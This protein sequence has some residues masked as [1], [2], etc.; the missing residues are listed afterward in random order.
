VRTVSL[1]LLGWGLIA[2][3]GCA[4][5]PATTHTLRRHDI[6]GVDPITLEPSKCGDG[7]YTETEV[8]D[9]TLLSIIKETSLISRL[10]VLDH[11][12]SEGA[13]EPLSWWQRHF[14]ESCA[15]GGPEAVELYLRAA[16]IVIVEM[17]RIN[18][19]LTYATMVPGREIRL[20]TEI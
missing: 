18:P 5:A 16:A 9:L 17:K 3:S 14:P 20:P 4:A 10:E 6:V 2:W 8:L 11:F 1:S 7:Q 19:G 13:L 12:F 15:G